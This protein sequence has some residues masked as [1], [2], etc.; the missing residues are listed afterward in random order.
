MLSL[1]LISIVYT[2]SGLFRSSKKEDKTPSE[3]ISVFTASNT[4]QPTKLKLPTRVV[5]TSLDWS[6]PAC[7]P[8]GG[9]LTNCSLKQF[10]CLP[11]DAV[12]LC[13]C[14]G[15]GKRINMGVWGASRWGIDF[16]KLY[17][18]NNTSRHNNFWLFLY[19]IA[20]FWCDQISFMFCPKFA[21]WKK[22]R[23]K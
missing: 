5:S 4:P 3:T 8:K 22:W 9:V 7:D 12:S 1:T 21:V 19:S 6:E 2:S 18:D 15:R 14:S 20:S 10:W 11:N 13:M 17:T 23:H 16:L